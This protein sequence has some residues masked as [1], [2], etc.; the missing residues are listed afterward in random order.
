MVFGTLYTATAVS[1]V[2]RIVNL[3]LTEQQNAVCAT[4]A[5]VFKGVV[6]QNLLRRIGG[7]WVAVLEILVVNFSVANLIREA[8]PPDRERYADRQGATTSCPTTRWRR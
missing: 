4:L 6:S 3:F 1:T 8:G 7:G 2:D 5:D